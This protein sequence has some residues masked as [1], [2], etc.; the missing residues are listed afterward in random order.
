MFSL[1]KLLNWK[2]FRVKTRNF[3]PSGLKI[4]VKLS[5]WLDNFH[6]NSEMLYPYTKFSQSR[7]YQRLMQTNISMDMKL[8]FMA[9]FELRYPQNTEVVTDSATYHN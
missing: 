3:N 5:K 9:D 4:D 6:A 1:I 2:T 7:I 8:P